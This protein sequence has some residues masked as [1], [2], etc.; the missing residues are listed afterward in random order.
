MKNYEKN[1]LRDSIKVYCNRNNISDEVKSNLEKELL[2]AEDFWR[3]KDT[4]FSNNFWKIINENF[5]DGCIQT[6]E[7]RYIN[8]MTYQEIADANG[9]TK[10]RAEQKVKRILTK[11]PQNNIWR[12]ILF[13]E[14]YI[15][16]LHRTVPKNN[17]YATSLSNRTKTVLINYCEKLGLDT[18]ISNI[19][20]N[21][22][23]IEELDRI[24]LKTADELFDWFAKNGYTEAVD[25]WRKTL[26]LKLV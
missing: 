13:D 25:K 24:G 8:K 16:T 26:P 14:V 11:L 1:I 6:L 5:T 12:K 4:E 18:T 19:A 15:P 9:F 20:N 17:I 3:D 22:N 21:L 23:N 7:M 10:T 2:M